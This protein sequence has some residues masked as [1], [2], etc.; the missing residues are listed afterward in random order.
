MHRSGLLLFE[1]VY[2]CIGE[3]RLGFSNVMG[4]PGLQ[5]RVQAAEATEKLALIDQKLG[6][7]SSLQQQQQQQQQQ[8]PGQS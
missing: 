2:G 3:L 1:N 8:Q 5:V 6:Q 7:V 4:D